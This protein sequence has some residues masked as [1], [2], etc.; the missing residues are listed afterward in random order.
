[1]QV[2]GYEGFSVAEPRVM[3]LFS[4]AATLTHMLLGLSEVLR[5]VKVVC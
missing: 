1:M 4:L 2:T 5:Q 3:R